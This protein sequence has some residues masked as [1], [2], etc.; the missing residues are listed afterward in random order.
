[1]KL[2]KK[3]RL[4][5]RSR[6]FP[7]MRPIVFSRLYKILPSF[8]AGVEIPDHW[9]GNWGMKMAVLNKTNDQL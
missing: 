2:T 9:E 1:M 4:K 7:D 3:Q 8:L 5:L 6:R